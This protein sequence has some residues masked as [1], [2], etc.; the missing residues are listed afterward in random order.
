MFSLYIS[1]DT[2]YDTAWKP[3]SS[4]EFTKWVCQQRLDTVRLK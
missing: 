2:V 3:N 1:L 4:N